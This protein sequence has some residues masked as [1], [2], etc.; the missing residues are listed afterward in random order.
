VGL[1][2]LL[3]LAVGITGWVV[4]RRLA[5]PA[6]PVAAE[7]FLGRD[8]EGWARLCS[9]RSDPGLRGLV[10]HFVSEVQRQ[11]SEKQREALPEWARGLHELAEANRNDA[12]WLGKLLP[13]EGL[14]RFEI[15]PETGELATVAVLDGGLLA[16][17]VG[18]TSSW[19]QST[20]TYRGFQLIPLDNGS[21]LGLKNG[22]L[23]A[24]TDYWTLERAVGRLEGETA[25]GADAEPA[26]R[27]LPEGLEEERWDLAGVL[28]NRQGAFHDTLAGLAASW[29]RVLSAEEPRPEEAPGEGAALPA[30]DAVESA[31][32]GLDVVTA[33][34]LE[35]RIELEAADPVAAWAWAERLAAGNGWQQ[36]GLRLTVRSRNEARRVVADLELEGVEGWM[37]RAL[38][39]SP[40]HS[41]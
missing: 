38:A 31:S 30:A 6:E 3:L 12:A 39:A 21:Y 35:G 36:D 34:R 25:E 4:F 41:R 17:A 7:A 11:D 14:V 29:P 1:W 33:D 40:D 20:E 8:A 5:E 15:S 23:L 18:W 10:S 27:P 37:T 28:D 22:N 16:R 19:D 13:G 2:V 26:P 24:A 9:V 32:F